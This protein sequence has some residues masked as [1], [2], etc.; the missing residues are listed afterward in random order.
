MCGKIELSGENNILVEDLE[1]VDFTDDPEY[2]YYFI[3]GHLYIENFKLLKPLHKDLIDD[4]KTR[5]LMGYLLSN[6][7]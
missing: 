1:E 2:I 3:V 6:M 5:F 7:E 4:E